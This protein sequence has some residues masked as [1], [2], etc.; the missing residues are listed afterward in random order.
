MTKESDKCE[1][2]GCWTRNDY[3]LYTGDCV[4]LTNKSY[5]VVK[6]ATILSFTRVI[7]DAKGVCKHHIPK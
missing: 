5:Y 6:D 7:T 2:C 3:N 1:N 4:Y